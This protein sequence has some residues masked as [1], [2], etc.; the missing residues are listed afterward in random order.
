MSK[1]KHLATTNQVFW[2]LF[3]YYNVTQIE[4]GHLTETDKHSVHD[5]LK[6]KNEMKVSTLER[7]CKPLGFR[8]ELTLVKD[9][10]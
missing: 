5:W 2:N 4:F 10:K 8:V 6:A 7:I 9:E 3:K 1:H